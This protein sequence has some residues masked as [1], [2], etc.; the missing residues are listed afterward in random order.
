MQE[1]N[2]KLH[3]LASVALAKAKSAA[4][5]ADGGGSIAPSAIT[6]F[7]VGTFVGRLVQKSAKLWVVPTNYGEIA[8]A[9]S[10]EN[11]QHRAILSNTKN[12]EILAVN[13]RV[14]GSSPT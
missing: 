2:L 8:I 14:V 12:C 11:A 9:V 5:K 1:S 6:Q 4:E 7:D 13:R 10:P 3:D